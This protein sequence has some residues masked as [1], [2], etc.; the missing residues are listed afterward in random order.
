MGSKDEAL[1]VKSVVD[2]VQRYLGEIVDFFQSAIQKKVEYMGE[3]CKCDPKVIGTFTEEVVRGTL[4][5]SLS[6]VLKKIEVPLRKA[7]DL[8]DWITISPGKKQGRVLLVETIREVQFESYE[9]A[10]VLMTRKIDGDEE[11]PEGVVGVVLV[12]GFSYPDVLAHVSV[13]ARNNK[14]LFAV[15]LDEKKG[16]EMMH[17]LKGKWVRIESRAREVVVE[18][19]QKEEKKEEAGEPEKREKLEI[20]HPKETESLFVKLEEFAEG[21]TGA[22]S[23]NTRI[24]LEK[25]I[26]DWVHFPKSGAVPFNTCEKLLKTENPEK[27]K[28]LELLLKR[29]KKAGSRKLIVKILHKCGELIK[30]M[31]F[32][33]ISK[34]EMR[35]HFSQM[36][37]KNESGAEETL[38]RIWASKYNERV[39]AACRKQGFDMMDVNLSVLVQEVVNA[40]YAFVIHTI[41]PSTG[42]PDEVYCELVVGLGE[43]LVGGD[44]PGQA[45]SFI[46]N[47]KSRRSE[48]LS[49]PNKSEI[50]K[51]GEERGFIFRSDSNAEDLPGFAGAGLF[52]SFPIVDNLR[53][54]ANYSQVS[55]KINLTRSLFCRTGER[56]KS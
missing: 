15:H 24:L 5:F 45:F 36:G 38:K 46:Y 9:E 6:M 2:R 43:T 33:E 14:A 10:T 30:S 31:N 44:F 13:R 40:K 7:A 17:R 4:F 12:N 55:K 18:E 11:V 16:G 54:R 52:D 50:M 26:A 37:I 1:K 23:K 42:N 51:T 19:T 48:V 20:H 29:L 35:E 53:R 3:R 56:E 34:A 22:K 25:G 47:K 32:S 8:P 39:F 27:M 21:V 41:N 49:Y 28:K